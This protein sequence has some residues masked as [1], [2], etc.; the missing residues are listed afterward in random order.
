MENLRSLKALVRYLKA[1]KNTKLR[2]TSEGSSTPLL[3]TLS[4]NLVELDVVLSSPIVA[5]SD[6]CHL[7]KIVDSGMYSTSGACFFFFGN[8]IQWNSKRQTIH[9]SSSMQSELIAACSASDSAVWYFALLAEFPFL[10][11][12]TGTPEPIPLLIDNKACLSVAN[13]PDN[14]PRTRHIALREFRI[15][16]YVELGQVR[17]L[18]CPGTHNVADHFTKL[19]KRETYHRLAAVMGMVGLEHH[20][21]MPSLTPVTGKPEVRQQGYV[22]EYF[23]KTRK[24]EVHLDFDD[25][26]SQGAYSVFTN[27]RG[28]DIPVEYGGEFVDCSIQGV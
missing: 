9:A 5:F 10:F 23:S 15:R 1:H 13:H 19:L 16:D 12:I 24:W 2:F 7:D 8:L 18:W 17:P 4:R 26:C 25:P 20:C 28:V 3:R 14:S 27:S 21:T 22:A 6:A 11:G